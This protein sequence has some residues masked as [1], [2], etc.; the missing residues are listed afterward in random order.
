[1]VTTKK[2]AVSTSIT[3]LLRHSM[4]TGA[5]FQSVQNLLED[6]HMQR[7]YERRHAFATAVLQRGTQTTL[8]PGETH[9]FGAFNDWHGYAGRFPLAAYLVSPAPL[10]WVTCAV[11]LEKPRGVFLTG[12]SPFADQ[13]RCAR[14]TRQTT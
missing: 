14:I 6:L 8:T 2:A 12:A 13:P 1:M 4:A 11:R 7:Y 10:T 9:G 5:S 3:K